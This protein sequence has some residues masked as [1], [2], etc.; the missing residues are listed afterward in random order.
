LAYF[1]IFGAFSEYKGTKILSMQRC[2][3]VIKVSAGC[4][5]KLECRTLAIPAIKKAGGKTF[6]L[7]D[8]WS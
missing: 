1:V 4:T 2:V 8:F 7:I 6:A 3:Q 5:I